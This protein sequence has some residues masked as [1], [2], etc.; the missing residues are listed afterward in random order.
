MNNSLSIVPG[1]EFE[2]KSATLTLD[3][4]NKLIINFKE[5]EVRKG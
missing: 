2:I 3:G 1:T 4:S 5:I